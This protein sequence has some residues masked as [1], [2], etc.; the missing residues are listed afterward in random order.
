MR[1]CCVDASVAIKWYVQ[2]PR[3]EAAVSL[4]A[5]AEAG[6]LRIVAPDLA[7]YEM[8][9]ALRRLVGSQ[10]VALP[11]AR[12]AVS[13]FLTAVEFVN[14][15]EFAPDA[16]DLAVQYGIW[17]YDASY[18]AVASARGCELWTED[19]KILSLKERLPWVRSLAELERSKP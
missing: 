14:V 2:E 18:L 5:K 12:R 10:D 1:L 15:E 3:S 7:V 8:M 9:S 13:H 11:S 6:Q 19:A 17:T 16:L 4:L